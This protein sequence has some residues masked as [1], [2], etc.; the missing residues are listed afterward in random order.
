MYYHIIIIVCLAILTLNLILN[1]RSLKIPDN[2]SKIP[3]PAPR[4]SILIPARNEEENIRHC[5]ESLRKQ[6]YP[7]YEILVL[8]DNSIDGTSQIVS[9]IARNDDRVKL[10][11]G[12]KLPPGWAGK[13]HA[14]YQLA[15]N[16]TGSWLLF[17]DADTEHKPNM[18]RSVMA[19]ALEYKPSLLSGFPRQIT[20]DVS[21]KITVPVFYFII[22]SWLPMWWLH[23]SNKPKPSMANGQFLLFPKDEYWKIGGHQAVKSRIL[24]DVVIGAEVYKKG[25]RVLAVD[26][27]PVVS[28][29]MYRSIPAMWHGFAKS[30]YA[31]TSP[32]F[33][34]LIL[35]L[36]A[37]A[38]FLGPFYSLFSQLICK[39]APVSWWYLIILEIALIIFMRLLVYSHFKESIYAVIFHPVGFCFFLFNAIYVFSRRLIGIGISWKQRLY[40]P[41]SGVD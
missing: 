18:I 35:G 37:Y 3:N 20:D 39:P 4:V 30:I 22:M 10:L 19:L 6:D 32:L 24:E 7:D 8:D 1:L 38:L 21:Q 13:S 40:K 9:E 16:A 17:T 11:N 34:I 36:L 23:R 33:L 5:V 2:K 31:F 26:L 27:S 29:H 14:C 41:E 28:C 12:E 15:Q 25:G